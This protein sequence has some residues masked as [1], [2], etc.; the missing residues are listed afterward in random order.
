M[1]R[2]PSVGRS[3]P[4][5]CQ[6]IPRLTAD[7]ASSHSQHGAIV[8]TFTNLQ[9]ST[10][11]LNWATQLHSIGLRS[12]VGSQDALDVEKRAT[13]ARVGAGLFCA[14][15]ERMRRNG[16]AGRWPEVLP[17]LRF[18]YDVLL[19]DSDIGWFR[20]PLPYFTALRRAHPRADL[21]L[22][23][24][25]VGNAYTTEPLPG[26]AAGDLDLDRMGNAKVSSINI[27]V[28]FAYAD[29]NASVGA[30]V[31][32]WAEAVVDPSTSDGMAAW[33][34]GPINSRVLRPGMGRGGCEQAGPGS[35]RGGWCA[36]PGMPGDSAL[37]TVH[38]VG[39]GILP[40]LQFTTAFTYYVHA[41]TVPRPSSALRPP[42]SALRPLPSAL[43]CT[44]A[45]GTPRPSPLILH[46]P[47]PHPHTP[48]LA[49]L[50]SASGRRP[51]RTRC[52]RSS[53]TASPP[54]ARRRSSA[55]R[56]CGTTRPATT[57]RGS[58]CSSRLRRR[59]R[60]AR[61]ARAAA[62]SC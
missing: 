42:P 39:L 8:A 21:L 38:G 9:A 14:D 23:S 13:L 2:R 30:L 16:Q 60:T 50:R 34:Q 54:S 37:A 48:P 59:R 57:Q 49:Y 56:G 19:S 5:A 32:R 47:S 53:R 31:E 46:D 35:A 33:D 1:V 17:L 41:A 10:F 28:F 44:L 62:S 61:R 3:T 43:A 51:R 25:Y 40:M 6:T 58:S 36:R 20:N 12:L 52:T 26:G 11:A 27:G 15:G 18:G 22:C 45:F 29:A 4:P 7:L 55:R 24:D